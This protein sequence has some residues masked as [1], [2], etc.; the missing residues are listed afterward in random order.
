MPVLVLAHADTNVRGDC[1]ASAGYAAQPL[2][3]RKGRRCVGSAE[4]TQ[5]GQ[6]RASGSAS[7]LA[8][9]CHAIREWA[10]ERERGRQRTASRGKLRRTRR[11][12]PCRCGGQGASRSQCARSQ[13]RRICECLLFEPTRRLGAAARD[14][15]HPSTWRSLRCP[16]ARRTRRCRSR[17]C[18][19]ERAWRSGGRGHGPNSALLRTRSS[20]WRLWGACADFASGVQGCACAAKIRTVFGSAQGGA[21]HG[22]TRMSVFRSTSSGRSGAAVLMAG[23]LSS[24]PR[25]RLPRRSIRRLLDHACDTVQRVRR[26]G[27]SG[28]R[29]SLPHGDCIG[30]ES[31]CLAVSLPENETPRRRSAS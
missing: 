10:D 14:T 30:D 2:R 8:P 26:R 23:I 1:R 18:I 11:P 27:C 7:E 28:C 25:T 6:R 21:D 13:G 22:S 12:C 15:T 9:P 24:S 20:F 19:C 4:S 3:R 16:R 17:C 29:G 5:A 31:S